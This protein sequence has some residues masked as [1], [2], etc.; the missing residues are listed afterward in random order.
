M[1]PRNKRER[2]ILTLHKSLRPLTGRQIAWGWSQLPAKGYYRDLRKGCGLVWCSECGAT[3]EDNAG[4]LE[5]S[6]G[7][8]LYVCPKCGK[9]LQLEYSL[10][11]Q[12]KDIVT[13]TKRIS[14][15]TTCQGWQVVRTFDFEVRSKRG[16]WAV[17]SI[18][19]VFE[20]WYDE[21]GVE[22]II[23]IDYYRSIYYSYWKYGT[24]MSIKDHNGHCSGYYVWDDMF[25]TEGNYVCPRG[26]ITATLKRNGWTW[27]LLRLKAGVGDIIQR[28][29]ADRDA[30]WLVKAKQMKLLG[31][32]CKRGDHVLPYRHSVKVALRAGYDLNKKDITLWIDYLDLL[33]DERKDLHNAHYVC[34]VN[35]RAEHDRLVKRKQERLEREERK[36]K[37]REAMENESQYRSYRGM[38]LGIAFDDGRIYCHVLQS[39]KEFAEEAEVMHHCVFTN[40]YWSQKRHPDSLIL[41]A[42]D[43]AG[44]RVETVEVNTKTWQI[45]QSRGACN[46]NTAYHG[47]IIA[48][49]GKYIP[50][51]VQTAHNGNSEK[52][53]T[54]G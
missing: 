24:D 28:L 53:T 37:E 34:P 54:T 50:L 31:W 14:F 10:R 3:I 23:G 42:R 20:H 17:R 47:E 51:M 22:T 39:V 21:D 18:N 4:S 16:F 6:L 8:G 26:R 38:F 25:T 35:L 40:G 43:K 41:S 29:L 49:V 48:L 15:L 52:I 27:R 12:R 32:L 5:C 36:K 9:Q 2:T 7:E 44:K 11:K 13:E 46:Q 19:E 1:K 45:V 30:E 33:N